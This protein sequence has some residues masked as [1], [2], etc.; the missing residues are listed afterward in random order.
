MTSCFIIT[1]PKKNKP[2]T[3][4]TR[5]GNPATEVELETAAKGVVPDN[6][7]QCNYCAEK[8]NFSD[9]AKSRREKVPQEPIPSCTPDTIGCQL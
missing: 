1:K 3:I 2:L 9:W 4:F 6:T 8:K 5:F 7:K